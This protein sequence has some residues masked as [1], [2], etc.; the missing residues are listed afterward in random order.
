MKLGGKWS[1]PTTMML[2]VVDGESSYTHWCITGFGFG[3][4]L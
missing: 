2:S 3:V 4:R 1:L